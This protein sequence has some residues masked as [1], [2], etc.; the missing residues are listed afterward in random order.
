VTRLTNLPA[1]ARRYVE[2]VAEQTAV[3]ISYISVGPG[4]KQFIP[5]A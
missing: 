2:F 1:N 4:R 3:P 5:V